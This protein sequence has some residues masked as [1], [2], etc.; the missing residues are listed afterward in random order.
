MKIII[1][2]YTYIHMGVLFILVY[3]LLIVNYRNLPLPTDD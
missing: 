3:N 2:K 1:N